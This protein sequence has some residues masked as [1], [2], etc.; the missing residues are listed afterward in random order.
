[1]STIGACDLM[2]APEYMLFTS[3]II[4]LF[5][6][7]VCKDTALYSLLQISEVKKDKMSNLLISWCCAVAKTDEAGDFEL[8]LKGNT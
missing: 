8:E 6:Q 7:F 5:L 2:S 1:M 3:A 4:L